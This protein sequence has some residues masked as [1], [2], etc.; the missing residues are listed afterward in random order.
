MIFG[1]DVLILTCSEIQFFYVSCLVRTLTRR[2]MVN[3]QLCS[4]HAS[5]LRVYKRRGVVIHFA[6][7]TSASPGIV[8]V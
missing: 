3:A 6:L 8:T 1:G 5:S 2:S 7:Q 4:K